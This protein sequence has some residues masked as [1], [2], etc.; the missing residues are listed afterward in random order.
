MRIESTRVAGRPRFQHAVGFFGGQE[1]LVAQVVPIVEAAVSRS[2]PIGVAL[3]G[4]T[5]QAV[6]EAVGG[7]DGVITFGERDHVDGASAQT[8]AARQARELRAIARDFGNATVVSEHRPNLDGRDGSFWTELDAAMNVACADLPVS[9]TCFFPDMPLHPHVLTGARRN[10]PLLLVDGD[11]RHNPEHRPPREV[12][13]EFPPSGPP[14]LGPPH[15]K[16]AY[17]AWQLHDVRTTLEGMLLDAGYGRSRAEDVVLAV[18]EVATNAVEHGTLEAE[19][20]VWLDGDGLTC[21]VHDRGTLGDRLP[22]LRV[23][24]PGER[25]GRGMWVARQ[26]CDLLHVWTDPDGTHVRVRAAR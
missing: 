13:A 23:P 19:L 3:R 2:E 26:V 11:L 24:L 16:M 17:R 7:S 22:G 21:E 12:L 15:A 5:R 6:L 1:D 18:N 25:R 14:I 8:T 9:M 10:H 20:L 4:P